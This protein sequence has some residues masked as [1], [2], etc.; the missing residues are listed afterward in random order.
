MIQI[1]K[2][3]HHK[4]TKTQRR[5]VFFAQF[6]RRVAAADF[7]RGFQSTEDSALVSASRQRRD[8]PDCFS[9]R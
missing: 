3:L 5:K 8:G 7:S 9:R 6:L 2:N 4:D 1:K